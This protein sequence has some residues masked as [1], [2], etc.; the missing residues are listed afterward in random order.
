MPVTIP[1]EILA[2]AHIDEPGLKRELAIAFFQQERLALGQAAQLAGV[3]Q[4]EFQG[5]LAERKIPIH[6]GIEDFEADLETLRQLG[7]L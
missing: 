4:L 6:Y 5:L 1:D 2:A 3:T 7:R